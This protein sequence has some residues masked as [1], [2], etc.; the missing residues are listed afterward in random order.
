MTAIFGLL[1]IH[2]PSGP[3]SHDIVARV[4]HAAQIKRVGHAGTL[5]PLAE[6]VLIL[7][8]GKA[9]RLV[10]YLMQSSKQYRAQILLGI[11][12]TTYD[13]EGEIVDEQGAPIDFSVSDI[14]AALI[15]FRGE[16]QQIPPIYSAIKVDGKPAYAR[17]RAGEAVELEARTVFIHEL[18]LIAF[19]PP[20]LAL[21]VACSPGTYV[22]TLAHDLGQSLG[23]GAVL[24]GLT[25]TASGG[26]ELA[27]AVSWDSLQ[28]DFENGTWQN[29]LI[30][31]DYALPNTPKVALTD[32]QFERLCNGAPFTTPDI[33]PGLARAYAPDGR[34]VAVIRGDSQTGVWNPHKVF[35]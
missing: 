20:R 9:T 18:D 29:H 27:E 19:S 5:D 3:T 8:L 26:F 24:E 16:I 10:E 32:E 34:F 31:A 35:A 11:T 7:A 23:C 17:A 28:N 2:K 22:R 25:R 1:N 30:P 13:I 6:G 14:E 4:R 15:T 33:S 21:D 12:S